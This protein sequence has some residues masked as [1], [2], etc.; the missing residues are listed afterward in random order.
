[1]TSLMVGYYLP[2]LLE[3]FRRVFPR[4][5]VQITEDRRDYLEHL[6]V[7]GELDVALIVVS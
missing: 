1:M 3:R 6:L 5:H 4:I 2:F 7:S